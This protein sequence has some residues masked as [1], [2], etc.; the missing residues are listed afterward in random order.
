M[1]ISVNAVVMAILPSLRYWNPN[2]S[3]QATRIENIAM[4]IQRLSK[5]CQL[6]SLSL[7]CSYFTEFDAQ[8]AH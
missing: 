3:N 1:L 5:I 7:T 2:P 8:P 6:V 4:D